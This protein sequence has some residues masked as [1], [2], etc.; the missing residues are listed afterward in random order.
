MGSL[1]VPDGA[2][3]AR[4]DRLLAYQPSANRVI[5]PV[6]VQAAAAF[7]TDRTPFRSDRLDRRRMQ[8]LTG[9]FEHA[10]TLRGTIDA[11]SALS[12][13]GLAAFLRDRPEVAQGSA[14]TFAS[15][16]RRCA[17]DAGL[18]PRAQFTAH[19]SPTTRAYNPRERQ[20]LWQDAQYMAGPYRVAYELV[21]ALTFGAGARPD[22]MGRLTWADIAWRDTT[23][24]VTLVNAHG[25]VRQVPVG[26]LAAARMRRH[27]PQP[28]EGYVFRPGRVDRR[29]VIDK[30]LGGT[31]RKGCRR[32]R[33]KARFARNAYI[34]DLL[35]RPI[36][37]TTVA[38]VA[39]LNPGGSLT[40]NLLPWVTDTA[41][42]EQHL[43]RVW[44]ELS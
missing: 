22:E 43:S 36:P 28:A 5:E 44:K 6:V 2:A 1:H 32:S 14:N 21:W 8:L 13:A 3:Q 4:L 12:E 15:E 38:Y 24:V 33:L 39:D 30:T 26:E 18:R 40:Q 16:L 35:A 42:S 11:D 9:L 19:R 41:D 10:L 37:F 7:I 27:V 29:S 17:T 25:V 20:S 34:A 23:A 31:I